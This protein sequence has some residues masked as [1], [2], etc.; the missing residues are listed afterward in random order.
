MLLYSCQ[1]GLDGPVFLGVLV[2][3]AEILQFLLHLVQSQSVG[4]R[5]IDVEGLAGNLVLLVGQLAA[6]GA[7]VVQTVRDLHQYHADV[8]AH[9]QQQFLERLGLRGCLVAEDAAGDFGQAVHN[10]GNLGTEDIADILYGIVGIL[11]HV[12]Q[13]GGADAGAAQTYLLAGNLRYGDGVHD[14]GLA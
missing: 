11:Y 10:L 6:Q 8:V 12:M 4:Q 3:E 7:H 1:L 2:A 14:I 13:K 9:G 5:S